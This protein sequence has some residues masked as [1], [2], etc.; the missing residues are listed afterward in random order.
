MRAV[1]K[2]EGGRQ[3]ET[4][5]IDFIFQERTSIPVKFSHPRTTYTKE[6]QMPS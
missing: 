6:K 3:K 2:R 1:E 5:V 4:E